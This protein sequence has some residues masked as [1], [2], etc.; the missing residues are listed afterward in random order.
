ME[1]DRVGLAKHK[2]INSS[3]AFGS[4]Y[5]IEIPKEFGDGDD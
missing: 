2:A 4:A 5:V 1:G 3:L